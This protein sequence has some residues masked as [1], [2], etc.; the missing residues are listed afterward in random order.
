MSFEDALGI[1]ED[2]VESLERGQLSLEASLAEYERGLKALRRCYGVLGEAQKRI[3]VLGG[4]PGSGEVIEW[5]PAQASPV[6]REAMQ[7]LDAELDGEP[8]SES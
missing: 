1:V 2:A 3:E 5:K 7:E 4:S 8:G 6:L